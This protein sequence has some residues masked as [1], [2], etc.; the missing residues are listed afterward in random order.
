MMKNR[1]QF[2]KNIFCWVINEEILNASKLRWIQ[3]WSED[4]LSTS[5]NFKVSATAVSL[6]LFHHR[7][8]PVHPIPFFN[9]GI[10]FSSL[11][12]P[13]DVFVAL[14]TGSP[15]TIIFLLI[16]NANVV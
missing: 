16:W 2:Q 8:S 9:K 12:A 14:D 6:K 1:H 11:L 10:K 3:F 13:S 4:S 7:M 15:H 5:T